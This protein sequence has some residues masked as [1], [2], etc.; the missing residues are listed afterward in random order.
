MAAATP[1]YW[2]QL[3]IQCTLL[4]TAVSHQLDLRYRCCGPAA[5]PSPDI[6]VKKRLHSY[7]TR[8]HRDVTQRHTEYSWRIKM[9]QIRLQRGLVN[10]VAMDKTSKAYF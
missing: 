5:L 8:L 7:C 3:W 9:G 4:L 6:V 2:T 10:R 1:P